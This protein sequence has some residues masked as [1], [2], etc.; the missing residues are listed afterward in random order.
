MTY[1]DLACL[2]LGKMI[3]FMVTILILGFLL[4][5]LAK[6]WRIIVKFILIILYCP[7]FF[8]KQLLIKIGHSSICHNS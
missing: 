8:F 6:H 4:F 5:K 3:L 7:F 2:L 1:F